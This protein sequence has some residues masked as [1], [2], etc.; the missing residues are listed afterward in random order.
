MRTVYCELECS[1]AVHSD[2]PDFVIDEGREGRFGVEVTELFR[3]ESD[4]RTVNHPD[5]LARLFGGG[6]HLHRDDQRALE[7]HQVAVLR[8]GESEQEIAPGILTPGEPIVRRYERLADV[9]RRK[10]HDRYRA[11]LRHVSLIVRDRYDLMGDKR[12]SYSI[13]EILSAGVREALLA[14]HLHDVY[15]ITVTEDHKQVYRP[16]RLLLMY[17]ALFMFGRAIDEC[18][19]QREVSSSEELV[20]L[21]GNFC[22]R[23]GVD[24]RIWSARG[25]LWVLHRSVAVGFGD[26]GAEILDNRDYAIPADEL[27]PLSEEDPTLTDDHFN[28]LCEFLETKALGTEYYNEAETPANLRYPT[29]VMV[30]LSEPVND[31]VVT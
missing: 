13:S 3:S 6:P 16:V 18:E 20:L 21:F 26:K 14:S 8:P 2:L 22:L 4:A 27:R 17:E 30:R 29:C 31:Q 25:K 7:V 9:I 12:A 23:S 11:G 24:V 28:A 5:Y 19:P 15:W 10:S 1:R